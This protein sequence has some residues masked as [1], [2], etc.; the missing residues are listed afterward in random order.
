MYIIADHGSQISVEHLTNHSWNAK[1]YIVLISYQGL[2]G[3][4]DKVTI[5]SIPQSSD[6][7]FLSVVIFY[8][9]FPDIFLY[10]IT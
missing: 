8:P 9:N 4:Y 10:E 3:Y 2:S 6:D 5:R 7:R 1:I